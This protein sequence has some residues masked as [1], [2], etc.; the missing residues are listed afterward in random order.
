MIF[1]AKRH[2]NNK[3]GIEN[4]L[5][6]DETTSNLFIVPKHGSIRRFWQ[7]SNTRLY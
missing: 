1:K 3:N 2:Q 6:Q 4:M 7:T 5:I